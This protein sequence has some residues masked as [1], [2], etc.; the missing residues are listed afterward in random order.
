MPR[1]LAVILLIALTPLLAG[2]SSWVRTFGGEEDDIGWA[3]KAT[4]D[5]GYIVAG[6]TGNYNAGLGDALLLKLDS[7]GNL[8]WSKTLGGSL[9]DAAFD[10]CVTA[11]GGCAITGL[12][13][14][15]NTAPGGG[16]AT[17]WLLRLDP[18]GNVLWEKYYIRQASS[19][20]YG[21][22]QTG[23]EG[24]ILA[25]QWG[26]IP[27]LL[28][29]DSAG[30]IQWQ[31]AYGGTVTDWSSLTRAVETPDGG[32]A[33]AGWY[34]GGDWQHD[35]VEYLLKVD[36]TG[37]IL[38]QKQFQ[39]HHGYSVGDSITTS[40][41]INAP[42]GALVFAG[43]NP[44]MIWK[45]DQQGNTIW[46]QR[47]TNSPGAADTIDLTAV[48]PAPE[49]GYYGVGE[50]F[51]ITSCYPSPPCGKGTLLVKLSE[52][53]ALEWAKMYLADFRAPS[54][55][56]FCV[57]TGGGLVIVGATGG[58]VVVLKVDADGGFSDPCVTILDAGL[59]WSEEP[60]AIQ[61]AA[62]TALD[63][64]CS[65][66]EGAILPRPVSLGSSNTICPVIQ[67]VSV[68]HNPFRLDIRG[69][70]FVADSSV[71]INGVWVPA[72]NQKYWNQFIAKKGSALKA[73]VPKG[74]AVCVTVNGLW[75]TYKSDCFVFTR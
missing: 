28:K 65:A 56:G 54:A 4:P 23:D 55:T 49:G 70:G 18:S 10:V 73:M 61:D 68:L 72:L 51:L 9:P 20:A 29:V 25:G 74:Q 50:Y 69:F 15:F 3:I 47:V 63:G 44:A 57:A 39:D 13:Y 30:N 33:A 1:L 38:W 45:L 58:D 32:F 67:S 37:Q 12:S 75:G 8:L 21:I 24:F 41:V 7:Q 48:L 16:W 36:S 2:A 42:D 11:D 31:R 60:A 34:W 43:G 22:S 66:L 27:F 46:A 53:G 40:D 17:P 71:Q 64:P 26:D 52:E 14:N 59:S 19:R 35:F 62:A 5:G 6:Q